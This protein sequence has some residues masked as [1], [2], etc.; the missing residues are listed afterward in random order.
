MAAH[1]NHA[2]KATIAL[3]RHLPQ[4]LVPLVHLQHQLVQFSVKFV[5]L[6]SPVSI[7]RLLRLFVM[8]GTTVLLVKLYVRYDSWY[9]R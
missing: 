7:P 8:P 4:Y 1:V 3:L 6:A 5:L 2:I 9:I